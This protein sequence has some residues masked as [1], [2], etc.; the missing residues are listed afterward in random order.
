MFGALISVESEPELFNAAETLK[1][2][3]VNQPNDQTPLGVIAE[4]NDV[5]DRIAVNPLRQFLGLVIEE[6]RQPQSNT[7]P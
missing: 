7:A 3:R 2:R 1:L 4:R 5:V 6:L